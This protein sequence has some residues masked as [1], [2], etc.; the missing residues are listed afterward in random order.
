L[1]VSREVAPQPRNV[2]HC[3][4]LLKVACAMRNACIAKLPELLGK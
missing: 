2:S 3:S 1:W 4:L